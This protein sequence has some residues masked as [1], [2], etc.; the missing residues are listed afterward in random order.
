MGIEARSITN[1]VPKTIK[2]EPWKDIPVSEWGQYLKDDV[3]VDYDE[4]L[5]QVKLEIV[6]PSPS[7]INSLS[8]ATGETK[9]K[10]GVQSY[11]T[12]DPKYV[13][14]LIAFQLLRDIEGIFDNGQP[15]N[16]KE[17]KWK[18]WFYNILVSSRFMLDTVRNEILEKGGVLRSEEEEI[19]EDFFNSP[20]DTSSD[21]IEESPQLSEGNSEH[22]A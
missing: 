4:E 20:E 15:I 17:K 12:K 3:W 14:K 2:I 13:A 19:D 8:A 9:F 21:T 5:R 10:K 11:I 1:D 16:Y 7:I 6:Y 18:N 22:T